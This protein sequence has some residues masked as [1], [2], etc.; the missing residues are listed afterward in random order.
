MSGDNFTIER[1]DAATALIRITGQPGETFP[2]F[3]AMM[4]WDRSIR[5]LFSVIDALGPAP[6]IAKAVHAVE[7]LDR[8]KLT[9]ALIVNASADMLHLAKAS[10]GVFALPTARVD[11]FHGELAEAHGIVDCLVASESALIGKFSRRSHA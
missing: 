2:D 7:A 9:L 11:R 10:R 1:P 3:M 6:N 5:R 4:R 8:R